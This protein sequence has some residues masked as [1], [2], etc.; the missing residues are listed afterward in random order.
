MAQPQ[1]CDTCLRDIAEQLECS[2]HTCVHC[3]KIFNK[4][5][6]KG[7]VTFADKKLYFAA[8]FLIAQKFNES[9]YMDPW[10]FEDSFDIDIKLILQAEIEILKTL[11]FEIWEYSG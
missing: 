1:D 2:E 8:S 6:D 9:F 5:C 11:E 3:V 4:F 10:F 7:R